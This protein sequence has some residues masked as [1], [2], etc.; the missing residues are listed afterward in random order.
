MN[1]SE[2][3]KICICILARNIQELCLNSNTN[4]LQMKAPITI[5]KLCFYE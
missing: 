2:I 3:E 4:H 1:L 5:E